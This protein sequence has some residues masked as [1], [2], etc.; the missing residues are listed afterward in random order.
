MIAGLAM[1]IFLILLDQAK[2][3]FQF[4]HLPLPSLFGQET[5]R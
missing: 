4:L 5:K 3:G 2:K 1:P